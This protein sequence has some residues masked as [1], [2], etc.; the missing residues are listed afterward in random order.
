M[1]NPGT[2]GGSG[3]SG[4]RPARFSGRGVFRTFAV[5]IFVTPIVGLTGTLYDV[6]RY[7]H[8]IP[9]PPCSA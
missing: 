3:G 5:L 7:I 6:I 2:S 8:A 1:M 9:W 4:D